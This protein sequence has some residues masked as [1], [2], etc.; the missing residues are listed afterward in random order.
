MFRFRPSVLLHGAFYRTSL[1]PIECRSSFALDYMT[2][3]NSS[4]RHSR[5]GTDRE[6]EAALYIS[7]LPQ[8][9]EDFLGR[10]ATLRRQQ[11]GARFLCAY[12]EVEAE[13]AD[14]L[15]AEA[16]YAGDR[17]IGAVS[18]GGYGHHVGRSLAF[19][20]VAPD[21][22]V[23]GTKLEVAVLGERRPAIVLAQPLF[24]PD[25]QRPRA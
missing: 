12:L 21:C 3:I 1:I 25:N 2:F 10:N 11:Q 19:A 6:G 24:D 16:V 7:L 22:A 18:S 8:K 20:Y 13:D 17:A 5:S 9:K 23:P 14:C 15:G 4:V